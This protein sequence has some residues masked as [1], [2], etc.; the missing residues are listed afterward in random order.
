[1]NLRTVS[2]TA[3]T[4]AGRKQT[5][6]INGKLGMTEILPQPRGGKPMM[7][8]TVYMFIDLF[9]PECLFLS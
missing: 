4:G 3:A 1:M 5:L 8:Y 6:Q 7:T 9:F 2:H